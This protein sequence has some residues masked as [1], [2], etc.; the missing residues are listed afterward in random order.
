LFPRLK[1]VFGSEAFGS[2]WDSDWRRDQ[3]I[4]SRDYFSRYFCYG[5][6][7]SEVSDA[8]L[9]SFLDGIPDSDAGLVSNQLAALVSAENAED[10]TAKLIARAGT[11]PVGVG[12]ALASAIAR[13]G[14][15]FPVHKSGFGFNG[16]FSQA[17]RFIC[18]LAHNRADE[19]ERIEFLSGL[20]EQAEP[21]TFAV[22]I[23]RF[24]DRGRQGRLHPLSDEQT[25]ELRGLVAKRIAHVATQDES[26]VTHFSKELALLLGIWSKWGVYGEADC[27]IRRVVG[28]DKAQAVILLRSY[29]PRRSVIGKA[30]PI[31]DDFGREQYKLVA[32]LVDP[33]IILEALQA[34]YGARLS[35]DDFPV[36]DGRLTDEQ[37]AQQFDWLHRQMKSGAKAPEQAVADSTAP[38]SV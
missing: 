30:R 1:S 20:L 28:E 21:I 38:L 5:V 6:S 19:A 18:E 9:R 37:L 34:E 24:V 11:I 10:L 16:A 29:L 36:G 4:A 14:S 13:N 25:L 35:V 33:H 12:E 31:D 26:F 22:E 3:R 17:A 27:Y 2:D 15:L 8:H 23:L 7:S 32:E